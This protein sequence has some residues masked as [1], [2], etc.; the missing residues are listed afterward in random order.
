VEFSPTVAMAQRAAELRRRGERVL[1]FSVGEPDQPTPR[2][3]ANAAIA[4][5]AAGQTRY[6][7]SAGIPELRQAVA[8]RYREDHG[9]E[10][11]PKQVVVTD[12]GKH[13]L[14]SV[15]QVLVDPGDQVIVPAPYWPT[16]SETVRLA[17]GR[18]VIVETREDEGFRVTARLISK[19][20]TER[21]RAI[22]VNTPNN[23]TGAVV[24]P[25][26]LLAIGRLAKRKK[27]AF[28]YDDTYAKL[29]LDAAE[30]PPL[31]ELQALLPKSLVVLGTASKSYCMTG[32]RIGWVLGPQAVADA[33]ATLISHSTQCPTS[34]AQAGAVAALTGSQQYV[35]RLEAEYR[36]RVKRIYPQLTAIPG[37]T[38]ARPSGGFYLFPSVVG[39]LSKR[40][41]SSMQL[42][43]RLLNDQK[44]AVVPGEGF[45]APGYLRISIARS[46]DELSEGIGRLAAFLARQ[47]GA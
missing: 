1:D 11:D 8:H 18:P 15:L 6:T 36:R 30:P 38:C 42:A 2:H 24:D 31:R 39:H 25:E 23:P 27:L 41:P 12:G 22:V 40:I 19:A 3:V 35:K 13:A 44:L 26:E 32:W 46:A 21:T 29:S 45:A 10:Y 7:P 14:F 47:A 33:V 20:V 28:L 4:A 16:F 9:A 37:I 34:F 5:L 17:G 43:M